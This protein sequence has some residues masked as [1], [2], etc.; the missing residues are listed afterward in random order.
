M[1][2]ILI[3]QPE[4]LP[5]THLF[6]KIKESDTFVFLDNVQ[7]NRRSFQNRNQIK[8]RSGKKWLT[9]PIKK[10]SRFELISNIKID[11]SKNWKEQH[12]KIIKENYKD[13]P[14]FALFYEELENLLKNSYENLCQLNIDL[15]IL[16]CKL[17][18]VKCNF[19]KLSNM[20][21]KSK[22]S[23][24]I[25]DICL[26]LNSKE[27][28]TGMGS[29]NYLNLDEF[30]KNNIIVNFLSPKNETYNQM[31]ENIGFIKDLSIVDKIFN[32]G[33]DIL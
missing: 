24:L 8:I 15:I 19:I 28:I 33:F 1:T 31:F 30:K 21:I 10:T 18:N 7:Y 16:I 9:I 6:E 2:K 3:H 17:L 32:K 4:Y 23:N 14:H 12:L 27:Y 20:K 11:N 25:L 29:Q 26:E 22:K 13:S 5:W